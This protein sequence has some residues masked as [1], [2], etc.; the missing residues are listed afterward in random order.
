MNRRFWFYLIPL[1]VVVILGLLTI[2]DFRSYGVTLYGPNLLRN[3]SFE[4]GNFANEPGQQLLQGCKILCGGSNEMDSWQIFRQP[5]NTAQGCTAD[6]DA[7]ARCSKNNPFSLTTD[8]GEFFVDLTGYNNRPPAQFGAIQQTVANTT[9]GKEYELSFR[10][11]SSSK[12]KPTAPPGST[13]FYS[14]TASVLGVKQ[15]SFRVGA[16]T[17]VSHWDPQAMSFIAPTGGTTIAFY[18]SGSGG[19]FLGI[20]GASLRRICSIL[21]VLSGCM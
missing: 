5:A 10:I 17:E 20:D 19:D 2:L 8:D 7:I 9:A 21:E 14:V 4:Q 18:G 11:G 16:A 1:T 12:Y 15:Q 13:P 6:P 3:P